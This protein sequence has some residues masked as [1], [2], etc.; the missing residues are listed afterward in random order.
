MSAANFEACLSEVLVSEGGYVNNPNDPGGMTN[1]GVTQKTWSDYI[2]RRATEADM[3]ALTKEMVAPLY[4]SRYWN[5]MHCDDWPAGVDLMVFDFG[6]NA[7]PTRATKMLQTAAGVTADGVAGQG[8][9]AAVARADPRQLI[10]ACANARDAYYRSLPTFSHFG[11]GWLA[12]VD[13]VKAKALSMA[14]SG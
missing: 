5:V 10:T 14:P 3:R 12:R 9:H 11:K 4:R 13:R 1:L 8:T 7:G 2:G 6:V